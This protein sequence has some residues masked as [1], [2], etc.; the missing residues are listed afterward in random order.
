MEKMA[1][2]SAEHADFGGRR[3]ADGTF[4]WQA[5]RRRVDGSVPSEGKCD[6]RP[7]SGHPKPI[8]VRESIKTSPGFTQIPKP[9]NNGG[10]QSNASSAGGNSEQSA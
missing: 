4:A 9:G 5:V 7:V 6:V 8:G 1:G 10:T 2:N 3:S